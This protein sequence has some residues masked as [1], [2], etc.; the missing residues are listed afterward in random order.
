MIK[1][2]L[3]NAIIKRV[4]G[5]T[6]REVWSVLS[7][8]SDVIIDCLDRGVDVQVNRIGKFSTRITNPRRW[9]NPRTLEKEL[10]P[11]K[12]VPVFKVSK[13]LKSMLE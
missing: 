2:D 11:A 7:A 13:L 6:Y 3:V 10:L 9:L 5:L 8:L 1:R 12:R 4:P